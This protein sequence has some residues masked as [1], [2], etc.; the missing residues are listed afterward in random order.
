MI[1]VVLNS[2]QGARYTNFRIRKVWYLLRK[3]VIPS[4]RVTMRANKYLPKVEALR[5][6][7]ALKGQDSKK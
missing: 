4:H 1:G 5:K 2:Y 7:A 6:P 3:Q